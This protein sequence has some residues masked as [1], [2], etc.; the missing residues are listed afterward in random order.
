VTFT[1][2]VTAKGGGGVVPDGTVTFSDGAAILGSPTLTAGVATFATAAL[3][4]GL[5]A[6]TADYS[7]DAANQIQGSKSNTVNQE[8]QAPSSVT[9]TS[10]LSPS[11]YGVPVTFTATIKPSGI[12][13]ATGVVN[14]LDGGVQIGTADLK[15]IT[16]Q[17]TLT[18]SNLNVG[19]HTITVDYKGDASNSAST[20]PSITQVVIQTQT[21]TL[22][23]ANPN[24]GIA[25]VPVAIKA[26]V[27]VTTGVATPQGTVTFV[28]GANTLGTATLGAGGTATINHTFAPGTYSIV[29]TYAGDTNDGESA[30]PPFSLIVDLATT[31]TVVTSNPN[32]SL[33]QAT[34]TFTAKVKGN[35]GTLTGPVTFL[36]DGTAMGA[37]VNLDNTGTAVFTFG[38]LAAGTHAIT[39]KYAGDTNDAPS[40][41]IAINQVVG[42]LPTV[43][44][45]GSSTTTG[46]PAQTILVATVVDQSAGPVPT[47]TVTFQN[48]PTV[49]GKG[50]LDST[51][52][53]T[54]TPNL[55]AGNYTIVAYYGGDATHLPSQSAQVSITGT[56]SSFSINVTPA[57]VSVKATENA[58]LTVTLTSDGSF[59]DTI[60]L[61]CATV[62][63][64]VTC[65]FSSISPLLASGATVTSQ[66][67]IDTNYPL[68]GGSQTMNTHTGDR[69]FN[70][71]G[72]FLPFS[73]IFGWMLWRFRKRHASALSTI[74]ILVLSAAALLFTGCGGGIGSSAAK[75]GTYVIQVTGTGVNSNIIH[76]KSVTLTIT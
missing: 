47:G 26:T 5:H 8:V 7:G 14:F 57:T 31:S 19:S 45:L 10:S 40:T 18:T 71:A 17:A 50:T 51:G 12:A 66:L 69:K 28:S 41:S 23:S 62:P 13:A 46:V 44:D 6:I 33:V 24:P 20:S 65:H 70:L 16:N 60:G 37:A 54:L 32:P 75:A 4:Q 21:S 39:A 72:L 11:N 61:G 22:V 68:T 63:P 48:G 9:V 38:G 59:T 42:K 35:G 3:T 67:T 76:Y 74:L 73:L 29:A 27:K 56:P 58:I 53:V 15:G 36:A 25:G 52:V 64:G 49:I 2:T 43:T 55:P 30:S 34:V 1:A